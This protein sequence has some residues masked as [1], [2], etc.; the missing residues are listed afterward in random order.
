M[1]RAMDLLGHTDPTLTLAVYQQVLDMGSA[2]VAELDETMGTT[3]R[4]TRPSAGDAP[5][6]GFS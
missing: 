6:T 5:R 1:R 3:G 2:A 4:P